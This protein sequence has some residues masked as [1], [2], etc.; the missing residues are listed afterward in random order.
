MRPQIRDERTDYIE[1]LPDILRELVEVE[2]LNGVINFQ[3]KRLYDMLNTVIDNMSF[4]S[5]DESTISRWES[6]LKVNTP[7]NSSLEARR[8]QVQSKVLS[9]PPINLSTLRE[10]VESFLGVPVDIATDA[11]DYTVSVTYRGLTELPDTTP[12]YKTVYELI[13]ANMALTISYAYAVWQ[14]YESTTWGELANRTWEDVSMGMGG[15]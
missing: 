14:E 8:A 12:L 13:P 6:I 11:A 10:V 5:A 7:I 3:F 4:L 1:L 9:Q 15:A 2:A